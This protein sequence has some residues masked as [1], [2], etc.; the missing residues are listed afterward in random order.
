MIGKL[1][2][3]GIAL[4][5]KCRTTIFG[6]LVT[7]LAAF[8]TAAAIG[9]A[10]ALAQA[11]RTPDQVDLSQYVLSERAYKQ[12][13]RIYGFLYGQH[14]AI[15]TMKKQFPDLAP[16]FASLEAQFDAAYGWPQT[17]ATAIVDT[18][19]TK[20]VAKLNSDF[21]RQTDALV[22][23]TFTQQE[24][25]TFAAEMQ[26]RINGNF[27]TGDI[28]QNLRWLH[29]AP[30]PIEEL[31]DGYAVSF[32]TASHPKAAGLNVTLSAPASWQQLEGDKP[33]IVQQWLSQNGSGDMNISLLARSVP[34][35]KGVQDADVQAL[36]DDG[37]G[38]GLI[39]KDDEVLGVQLV[40]LDTLP[41]VRLDAVLTREIAGSELTTYIR[42]YMMYGNG[43]FVQLSCGVGRLQSEREK[44]AKRFPALKDLCERMAMG[45]TVANRWQ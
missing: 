32:N 4:N 36:I 11:S 12:A 35:L 5:M 38:K 31:V 15:D 26:E 22:D 39:G 41:T 23:R 44:T 27:T 37:G 1:L 24:A 45:I 21:L 34:E 30:H 29:Y 13:A 33:H 10:S 7:L 43:Y 25:M 3:G 9:Q 19:G 17:T 40:H 18:L 20:T 14:R 16:T 8:T 28:I 2:L 42:Y 6:S